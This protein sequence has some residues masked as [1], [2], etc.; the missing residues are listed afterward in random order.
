M[1]KPR[2][3]TEFNISALVVD[4]TI[5]LS[6]DIVSDI[7]E[8][9][10]GENAIINLADT[11]DFVLCAATTSTTGAPGCWGRTSS[12]STTTFNSVSTESFAIVY[13]V[14]R[15]SA[16]SVTYGPIITV[17]PKG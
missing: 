16:K 11:A 2:P 14:S 4:G 12:A 3:T 7:I 13:A 10:P 9:N 8:V 15:A 5:R 1:P 17:K 6:G